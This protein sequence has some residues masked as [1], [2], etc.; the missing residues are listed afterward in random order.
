MT[1][2]R[3]RLAWDSEGRVSVVFSMKLSLLDKIAVLANEL[4]GPGTDGKSDKHN[5]LNPPD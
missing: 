4:N 2:R 3:L 1:I 5:S